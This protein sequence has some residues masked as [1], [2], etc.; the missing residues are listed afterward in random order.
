MSGIRKCSK[1]G[2]LMKIQNEGPEPMRRDGTFPQHV[3]KGCQAEAGSF[4]HYHLIVDG[5][6]A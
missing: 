4:P 3:C 5:K 1:C 6:D 2:K